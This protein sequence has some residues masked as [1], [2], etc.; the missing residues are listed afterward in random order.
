MNK[1]HKL[2]QFFVAVA[3]IFSVLVFVAV[4][5]NLTKLLT[6]PEAAPS[7]THSTPDAGVYDDQMLLAAIL[8]AG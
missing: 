1:A 7:A 2:A 5:T 6:A 4:V 8:A 3:L